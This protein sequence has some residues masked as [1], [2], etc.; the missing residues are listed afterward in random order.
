MAQL[1]G[2]MLYCV[3]ITQSH[4]TYRGSSVRSRDDVGIVPYVHD[5]LHSIQHTLANLCT[6]RSF[7]IHKRFTHAIDV[8]FLGKR[9]LFGGRH[10]IMVPN[11]V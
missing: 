3:P 5:G 2:K 6:C 9:L 11:C 10:C 1:N 7:H 4:S 8:R